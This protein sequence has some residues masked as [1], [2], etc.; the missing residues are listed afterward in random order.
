MTI[1]KELMLKVAQAIEDNPLNFDMGQFIETDDD[2]FEAR[3]WMSY[4]DKTSFGSRR[5][6]FE[7][8][9]A[10]RINEMIQEGE[11]PPCGTA[12]CIAGWTVLVADPADVD[13]SLNIQHN[14]RNLLG[15]DL[16]SGDRLFLQSVNLLSNPEAAVMA[17]RLVADDTS[18]REA[19]MLAA[20]EHPPIGDDDAW[21]I[22]D[23]D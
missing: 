9:V 12:G 8:Q 16:P 5:R 22:G 2:T 17:L 15:L 19:V 13:E 10:L 11:G 20:A 21:E 7:T 14:A 3:V 23:D 18:I 6:P 1:N 4:Q